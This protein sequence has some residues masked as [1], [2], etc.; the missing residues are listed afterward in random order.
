[1]KRR[2]GLV[3]NNQLGFT[4]VRLFTVSVIKPFFSL[5]DLN[6][7]PFLG[8]LCVSAFY[9]FLPWVSRRR[10]VRW[11]RVRL[12]LAGSRRPVRILGLLL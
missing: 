5:F 11:M 1:M 7:L 3:K 6:H 9:F 12:G 8:V 2:Q 4:G 10:A